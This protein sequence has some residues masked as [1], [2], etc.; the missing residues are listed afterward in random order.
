M[1]LHQSHIPH[2]IFFLSVAKASKTLKQFGKFL[3]QNGAIYIQLQSGKS[4]EIFIDEPFKPGEKLFLN[5][6]SSD[7]IKSLLKDAGFDI[8]KM[9]ERKSPKKGELN[10]TKLYV[11][12]RFI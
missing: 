9:Y 1:N 10:F 2:P 11:I 4:E 8:I 7:E 3:K 5:V 6:I 12:A